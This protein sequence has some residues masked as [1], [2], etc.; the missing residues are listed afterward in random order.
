MRRAIGVAVLLCVLARVGVWT[1][2]G[3]HRQPTAWEYETVTTNLLEG[4]GFTQ[5]HL[6]LTY[7]S[8]HPP[9]FDGISLAVYRLVGHR[10]TAILWLQALFSCALAA[11]VVVLARQLTGSLA[12]AA[13]AGAA[14]AT[15]PG[16]L[17]YDTHHLH[18]LSFGALLFAV[19]VW[20]AVRWWRLQHPREAVWLGAAVG[21]AMYERGTAG[22]FLLPMAAGM[23]WQLRTRPR[24]A[25]VAVAAAL[26]GFALVLA[27]WMIRNTVVHGRPLLMVSVNGEL[28]W[29]G[30]HAQATGGALTPSGM[31]VLD[32]APEAFR[33]LVLSQTNELAQQQVFWDEAWR[34][35]RAHPAAFVAHTSQKLLHFFWF[36]PQSGLRYPRAFLRAYQ[37]YYGII[38]ALA[39]AG[40]AGGLASPRQEPRAQTGIMLAL[41]VSVAFAQSLFY[42]EGR[43]RW[44][45]EPLL[46]IFA[47]SGAV[48]GARAIGVRRSTP[49]YSAAGAGSLG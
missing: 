35:V 46:L 37:W 26:A 29:R 18:P 19:I 8:Y 40:A 30:N 9:L 16:L 11:L 44:G 33:V 24:Q 45:V 43:H 36:S 23:A 12:A 22:L 13:V 15:H 41:I 17:Y 48:M 21:L 6:G 20:A 1:A 49:R 2:T 14:V 38:L 27:P 4:R 7:R 34:Y 5:P 3:S 31:T 32:A 25:A 39:L 28:F 42:V 47:A 10:Q